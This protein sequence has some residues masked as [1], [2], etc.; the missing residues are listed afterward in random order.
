[1]F[2]R[3]ARREKPRGRFHNA[4]LAGSGG[5]QE[6]KVAN[7]PTRRVQAGQV[8]LIDV[9][10]LADRLVLAYNHA[11]ESRIQWLRVAAGFS[12]VVTTYVYDA[13]GQMAAEYG[14]SAPAVTGTTYLT[15]DHLGSTRLVTNSGV[16]ERCDYAPFGEELGA[17]L[18]GRTTTAHYCNNGYPTATP[19]AT[20]LKFTS[21]ERDAETGLDFFGARYYSGAQGRFTS[22]DP[23]RFSARQEDPQTWNR[24]VYSRNSPLRFVDPNGKYF[25]AANGYQAVQQFI[26]TLVRSD[27]GRALVERISADPRPTSISAERL[28]YSR[29]PEGT[30]RVTNGTTT[31]VPGSPGRVGGTSVV[32]DPVNAA[33]TGALTGQS[34]FKTGLVAFTH[35]LEHVADINNATS[36]SNAAA[37]GAAGDAPSRPGAN[38]TTGGTAE[39]R[40]QAI[41]N[42]IGGQA[43]S[44][45]PEPSADS[46]AAA[47]LQYGEQQAQQSATQMI[48]TAI[49]NVRS[50]R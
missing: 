20:E 38:N 7:R 13:M 6:E 41:V 23:S 36:F 24:Y 16:V 8:H 33:L 29:G 49:R 1:V 35:E 19:D 42:G 14:G 45:A 44:Y 37:A 47:I 9:D 32:L 17:G 43:S 50:L 28:P 40:A 34:S 39:G 3:R 10:Y 22:I 18:D 26:S 15:T 46:E 12:E 31:P 48:Q 5:A 2:P 25:V 30:I 27:A 4:R 11:T 21:K